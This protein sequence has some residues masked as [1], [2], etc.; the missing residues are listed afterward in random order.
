MIYMYHHVAM[1]HQPCIIS[2]VYTEDG[3]FMNIHVLDFCIGIAD[4][5]VHNHAPPPTPTPQSM[6]PLL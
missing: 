2:P 3:S 6:K 4:L 1:Y 5:M